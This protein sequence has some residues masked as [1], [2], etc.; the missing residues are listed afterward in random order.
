MRDIVDSCVPPHHPPRLYSETG[1]Q[2][3]GNA[4]ALQAN[5]N[6]VWR[7]AAYRVKAASSFYFEVLRRLVHILQGGRGPN[8]QAYGYRHIRQ[9]VCIDD[10]MCRST[11]RRYYL[12]LKISWTCNARRDV[13]H[14][15]RSFA[16][17]QSF[18]H[19]TL[20]KPVRKLALG[21][22]G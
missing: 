10:W 20:K 5:D 15:T 4:Q 3:V 8:M 12:W 18:S 22:A 11:E 7:T 19:D 17:I 1:V 2:D 6:E 21:C 9:S 13:L 16:F 14:N